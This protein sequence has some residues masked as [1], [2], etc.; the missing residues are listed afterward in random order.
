MS[1]GSATVHDMQPKLSQAQKH[2]FKGI[3][4]FYEDLEFLARKKY[5]G[6]GG[7]QKALLKAAEEVRGLCDEYGLEIICLQ[8]FAGADGILDV[9]GHEGNLEK[10]KLWFMLVKALRTDIIQIPSNTRRDQGVTGDKEKIT[11]DLKGIADA[12]LQQ[13]PVVR[14]AYE[15]LAW[16]TFVHTWEDAWEIVQKVNK[17][18]LGLC[19]D[20]FNIV[21]GIW[22]D[23]TA[24]DGKVENADA[25]LQQS[26]EKMKAS[27]DISKV[28]FIQVVGA[29]KLDPPLSKD[30]P[31]YD[32]EQPARMTWSRNARLFPYEEK[33]GQYLPV[34]DVART[35]IKDLGYRGWVSLELFSRSTKEAGS[36][37]PGEHAARAEKSW[38][39]LVEELQLE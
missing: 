15:N 6:E 8:P 20:T 23:P 18:N 29:E 36:D 26:L 13:D 28:W 30:H 34:A 19:L 33:E 38:K 14:F 39:K 21:G 22:A 12:G 17:P 5:R 27:L 3:E 4:V 16:G 32:E 1:L 9:G 2:G 11:A 31:W 35:L 25:I 7:H 37:V 10:L 24:K